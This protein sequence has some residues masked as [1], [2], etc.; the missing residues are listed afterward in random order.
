MTKGQ[1]YLL[2]GL[3]ALALQAVSACRP[4]VQTFSRS[5]IAIP[6]RLTEPEDRL[7]YLVQHYWD[8]L[9]VASA[10]DANQLRQRAED[11]CAL[12]VD[13]P[14]S[15]SRTS[16]LRSLELYDGADLDELIGVYHQQLGNPRSQQYDESLYQ[17]L[18]SW[19]SRSLRVD[20]AQRVEAQLALARL[21]H[22]AVGSIAQDITL[23]RSDS[24]RFQLHA[25][26]SPY[27]VLLLASDSDNQRLQWR[28]M[29][30]S[31]SELMQR[32]RS[33]QLQIVLVHTG[34]SRPDSTERAQL[35]GVLLTY[36]SAG[37]IQGQRRYDLSSGSTVYLLGSDKRVLLR[38]TTLPQVTLYLKGR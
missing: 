10:E 19:Q 16:L 35:P 17:V 25:L 23:Y 8:Q 32:Q 28:Q 27:I 38:S 30:S 33:H 9:P 34:T 7:N 12:A 5:H 6:A 2:Y 22:N 36:D 13:A 20:S 3:V 26:R 24:S 11:F 21:K 4:K 1:R 37:L 18:L 29:L 14:L 15:L 31:G